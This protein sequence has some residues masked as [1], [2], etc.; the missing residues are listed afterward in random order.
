LESLEKEGEE[1]VG[2]V[3][4]DIFSGGGGTEKHFCFAGS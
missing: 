2:A 1:K 3:V 4:R